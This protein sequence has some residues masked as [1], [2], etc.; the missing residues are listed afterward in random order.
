MSPGC[1]N[2]VVKLKLL[3]VGII[4]DIPSAKTKFL[5]KL[6]I[7][8]PNQLKIVFDACVGCVYITLTSP[9]TTLLYVKLFPVLIL[10]TLVVCV[11]PVESFSILLPS[12]SIFTTLL[13]R[14]VIFSPVFSFKSCLPRFFGGY[15]GFFAY[16]S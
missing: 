9:L 3:I 15:V 1:G 7:L 6:A 14:L 4:S 12:L 13:N 11:I 2:V 5:L 8:N 10:T 16:E